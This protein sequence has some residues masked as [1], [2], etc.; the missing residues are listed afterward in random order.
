LL[1]TQVVLQEYDEQADVWSVGILTYQ[2]LT[3]RFPFWEDIRNLS[4]QQVIHTHL[5]TAGPS[6]AAITALARWAISMLNRH[7]GYVADRQRELQ[8]WQAILSK[9]IDMAAPELRTVST[10]AKDLLQGLLERDPERRLTP[11][12]ALDHPWIRVRLCMR[13]Q[14][15]IA[16]DRHPLSAS[17][18]S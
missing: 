17:C 15:H 5:T 11:R 6:A 16:D 13:T 9:R 8:V 7:S 4:L 1:W 14:D 2:L 10:A 3:G 18:T 12:Q